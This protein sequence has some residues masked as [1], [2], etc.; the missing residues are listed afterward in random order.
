MTGI[1]HLFYCLSLL[2]MLT[3]CGSSDDIGSVTPP[4]TPDVPEPEQNQGPVSLAFSVSG[5]AIPQTRSGVDVIQQTGQ[6]FRGLTDQR[7]V[8]FM[9]QREVQKGDTP[10][11]ATVSAYDQ[12]AGNN[13]Q[14]F[15]FRGIELSIGTRSML[16]YAKA[17]GISSKTGKDQNGSTVANYPA[18]MAPSGIT[19]SPER[20][21]TG[22]IITTSGE[23]SDAEKIA[24]YLTTIANTT[25][26]AE[27]S[28]QDLRDNFIGKGSVAPTL[29]AGSSASV[30]AYVNKLKGELDKLGNASL[31]DAIETNINKSFPSDYPASIGLPDGAAALK[32]ENDDTTT[33]GKFVPQTTTALQGVNSMNIFAYPAELCYYVNSLI[34]T[35]DNAISHDGYTLETKWK[36]DVLPHYGTSPGVV[37]STTRAVAIKE[38]LQYGVARL[39]VTIKAQTTKNASNKDI[40]L[41]GEGNEIEVGSTSFPLTGII[42]GG[43]RQVGFDFKPLS[44]ADQQSMVYDRYVTKDDNTLA[45]L[46]PLTT[47]EQSATPAVQAPVHTLLLQSLDGEDETI[48]LEFENNCKDSENK[49]IAFKGMDGIINPGTKF[50]L[51]GTILKPTEEADKDYTKRVFTQDYITT[52]KIEIGSLSRAYNAVP[53][54]YF[55]SL[56]SFEVAGVDIKPWSD[57]AM[58]HSVYN[59]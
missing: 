40:L 38:P 8:A 49:G 13:A 48:I 27:F 24:D 20:I 58:S 31:K 12:T 14:F 41:D 28:N 52:A 15:F 29:I 22:S 34:Y 33:P 50:Y 47:A 44:A 7:F 45:Y 23:K 43:Q 54:L 11:P 4:P 3:A 55:N 19:F 57:K 35:S 10:Y 56:S 42:V 1:R 37:S 18:N 30:Q 9:V 16:A 51:I 36:E 59:W 6:P 46:R 21:F 2:S 26:W 5:T 17:K 53:D 25:G 32:W 39:D